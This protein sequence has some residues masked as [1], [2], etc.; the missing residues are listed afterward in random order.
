MVNKKNIYIADIKK[1]L[2]PLFDDRISIF[3]L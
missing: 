3:E 1:M 2:T